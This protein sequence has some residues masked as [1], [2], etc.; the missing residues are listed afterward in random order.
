M[1]DAVWLERAAREGWVVLTKDA[2]IRYRAAEI[3]A[4]AANRV[5]AFVLA[6]GNLSATQQA[7][8][9]AQNINRIRRACRE[10]G[11]F[12]YSVHARR[13]ERLWPKEDE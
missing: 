2:R 10:E 7:Q 11:P 13:I 1:R 9:F 4:L 12:V 6:R 3:G 8:W 5:R